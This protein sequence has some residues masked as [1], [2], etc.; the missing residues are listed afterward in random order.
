MPSFVY[1]AADATGRIIES[2][3]DGES[4][5]DVTRAL[6]QRGLIPLATPRR[7]TRGR[8]GGASEGPTRI[9]LRPG[10]LLELTRQ[11]KVMLASGITILSTLGLLRQRAR[12]NFRRLLDRIA[13]DI[14]RG[15]SLSEALA[16]HPRTFDPFYVGTIRAGEAAGIH[17]EALEELIN[18][19][20][21]RARLRRQ[22]INALTYPAIVVFTLICACVVML[23][24]VVPQFQS[25]F[26]SMK[27]ALPLPTRLLLGASHLVTSYGWL[28]GCGLAVILVVAWFLRPL[29][30]VQ[31]ALGCVAARL[32]LLGQI[33]YL[34]TVVQFAR[35]LA[36]LERAGLPL[37]ESLRVV[38]EMLLP[39]PVKKLTGHL[40]RTVAS[41]GSL[42]SAV[43]G[44]RA[45]PELVE[46]M[47]AVGE[48]TGQIDETLVAAANHY[49]EVITVR[50]QRLTTLLEPLLTLLVA[51]LVLCVALA[52][53]LPV[54]ETNTMWLKS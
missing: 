46:H 12:G 49:D 50:V 8:D 6:E 33:I 1:R 25:L 22:V 10:E 34:S 42:S 31:A 5:A 37:M 29:P 4:A 51:G 32:P 44:S 41:G 17:P 15:A 38:E 53:F 36:L 52:V 39:G 28:L 3:L 19:Y 21:R 54:W 43:A 7:V 40:R 48:Q 18:Y 13:A 14:Q 16:A 47:I 26:S 23:L 24:W 27:T 30:A 9:R 20:E 11:L 35:T 2:T 45:L